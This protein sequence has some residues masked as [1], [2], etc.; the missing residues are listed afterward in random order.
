MGH[1]G[2]SLANTSNHALVLSGT[3]K[4]E[5]SETLNYFYTVHF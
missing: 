5:T 2:F 1:P 4:C 3:K